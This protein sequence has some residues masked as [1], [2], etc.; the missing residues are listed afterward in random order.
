MQRGPASAPDKFRA[1]GPGVREP[2]ASRTNPASHAETLSS[3]SAAG[4]S[5]GASTKRP[6]TV[7]NLSI[8]GVGFTRLLVIL[9][10][11]Y[12]LDVRNTLAMLAVRRNITVSIRWLNIIRL[13]I[14]KK[15]ANP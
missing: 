10:Y 12:A 7:R 6:R 5:L 11:A 2:R 8:A 15:P 14:A 1:Q 3:S 13:K 4:D 9:R